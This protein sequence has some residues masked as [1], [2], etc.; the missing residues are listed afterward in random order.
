MPKTKGGLTRIAVSAAMLCCSFGVIY[1][2]CVAIDNRYYKQYH[3]HFFDPPARDSYDV[4]KRVYTP[5][6]ITGGGVHQK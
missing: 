1:G 3:S 6:E 4:D 2:L 5:S